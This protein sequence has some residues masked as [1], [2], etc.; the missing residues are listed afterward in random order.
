ML[1]SLGAEG[2]AIPLTGRGNL[3]VLTVSRSMSSIWGY[4]YPWRYEKTFYFRA[5]EKK[6]YINQSE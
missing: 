6:S 1:I 4:A 2:K 5:H 3:E